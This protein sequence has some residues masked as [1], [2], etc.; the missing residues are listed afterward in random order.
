MNNAVVTEPLNLKTEQSTAPV[1]FE[2]LSDDAHVLLINV[3]MRHQ[4]PQFAVAAQYLPHLKLL[5]SVPNEPHRDYQPDFRSLD[6]SVQKSL[7]FRKK[8][9]HKTGFSDNLYVHVPYDTFSQLG[10]LKPKS[11]VSFE[12]GA[13]SLASCIY[14]KMHRKTGLTI[15][16]NESEHTAASWGAAR[17]MLRPFILKTADVV[18]YNGSSGKRYLLKMGVPENRLRHMPYTAHP[19][20]IYTDSTN[21]SAADRHRLLYVGQVTERKNPLA[22]IRTLTRWCA[23]HPNRNVDLSI[24]GRG[25]LMDAVKMIERPSN[26]KLNILGIVDPENLPPIYA[27]HG[28]MVFPTLADEW[29]LV[30]NEAMHS[31]MPVLSSIYA[32]ATLDLVRENENGWQFQSDDENSTYQ[33][34]D[35]MM[36]T[37]AER[38]DEMGAIARRDVS[39]RTPAW[40]GRLLAEATLASVRA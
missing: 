23:E 40:S 14:R 28:V 17:R 16:V 31:G 27:Q 38:L 19:Q 5:L 35:R 36:N 8:W 24:V 29:G 7:T 12:L 15:V 10:R 26:F 30:V 18:T 2:V 25:P 32:Q 33:S 13:R 22:F 20:M 4:H 6:V 3:I 34:I 39:D 9:K 21:R 1:Q 37:S 11:I